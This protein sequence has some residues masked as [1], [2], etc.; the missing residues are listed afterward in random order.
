M[1]TSTIHSS[2]FVSL[3]AG[4]VACGGGGDYA[5]VQTEAGPVTTARECEFASREDMERA[6]DAGVMCR[7]YVVGTKEES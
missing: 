4:L 3:L 6:Q 5:E 2:L 1:K 7:V